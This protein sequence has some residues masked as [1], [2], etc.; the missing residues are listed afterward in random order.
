MN[1]LNQEKA[2]ARFHNSLP[3][4]NRHYE[5][6]SHSSSLVVTLSHAWYP[7]CVKMCNDLYNNLPGITKIEKTIR[8]EFWDNSA[9]L[10]LRKTS[11]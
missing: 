5:S 6:I 8:I 4:T 10:N 2:N 9:Y 1:R 7:F 11:E 3:I